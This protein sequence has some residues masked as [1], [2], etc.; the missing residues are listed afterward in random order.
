MLFVRNV[1]L[2]GD[3]EEGLSR[4][5]AKADLYSELRV[6]GTAKLAVRWCRERVYPG[7]AQWGERDRGAGDTGP[8][9]TPA[10]ALC[11]LNAPQAHGLQVC[12]SISCDSDTTLT[13]NRTQKSQL[14]PLPPGSWGLG[15][16][17]FYELCTHVPKLSQYWGYISLQLPAQDDLN[18]SGSFSK[19]GILRLLKLL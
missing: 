13:N 14:Q 19:L 4:G 8:K 6:P 10:E 16:S 9:G 1:A 11:S 2:L 12:Q 5:I 18:F 3:S 15:V 7:E 17:F